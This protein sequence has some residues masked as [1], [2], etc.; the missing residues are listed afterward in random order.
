MSLDVNSAGITFLPMG[1]GGLISAA[2]LPL[3]ERYYVRR[4]KATGGPVPEARLLPTFFVAP[5]VAIGLLYV[6]RSPSKLTRSKRAKIWKVSIF[7]LR[8]GGLAG[9]GDAVSR[10]RSPCWQ[11]FRSV[12]PWCSSFK[13]G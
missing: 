1:L 8:S 9:L 2:L 7:S 3:C 13:A 10:T 4:S 11:E 6:S 12:L 5:L